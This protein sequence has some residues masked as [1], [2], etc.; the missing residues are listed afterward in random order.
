MIHYLGI[1][2]KQLY[3]ILSNADVTDPELGGTQAWPGSAGALTIA[4]A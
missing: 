4:G 2:L 3:S 1:A